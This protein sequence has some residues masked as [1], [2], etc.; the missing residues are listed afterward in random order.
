MTTP[1]AFHPQLYLTAIIL[2]KYRIAA[3]DFSQLW[4][5]AMQAATKTVPTKHKYNSAGRNLWFEFIYVPEGGDP[6]YVLY[7]V[8]LIS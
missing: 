2:T 1:V 8:L 7:T 6:Y 3:C 5:Y 4:T